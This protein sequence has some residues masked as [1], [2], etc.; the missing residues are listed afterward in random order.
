MSGSDVI[1]AD[2]IIAGNIVCSS[3]SLSLSL[4]FP[5]LLLLYPKVRMYSHLFTVE[6]PTDAGWEAELNPESEIVCL[7]ARV[8]PSLLNWNPKVESNFQVL[9]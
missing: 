7:N 5:P 2:M 3:M 1:I 8:D 9:E 4:L 6:E